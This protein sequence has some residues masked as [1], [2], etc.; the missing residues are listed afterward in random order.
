ME[1]LTHAPCTAPG[2]LQLSS[3]RLVTSPFFA[4]SGCHNELMPGVVSDR[5]I[6]YHSPT[7]DRPAKNVLVLKQQ[8]QLR[9]ESLLMWKKPNSQVY[10]REWYIYCYCNEQNVRWLD[11]IQKIAHPFRT[12][13]TMYFKVWSFTGEAEFY[14]IFIPTLIWLGAPVEGM[15]VATM[16]C[17]SQYITGTLKDMVCCPRPPCPPLELRGK[18]VTH[19]MEYGF[20]STH[21]SHSGI[22]AYF[23]YC[24]LSKCFPNYAF[25]CGLGAAFFL[26]NV[27]FSR[28]YLGMHWIGD[29]VGGWMV[30]FT[31]IIIQASFLDRWLSSVLDWPAAPCWAYM[32]GYVLLHAL[33]VSHAT[34]HDP[35]PCYI[36]SLRFAGVMLG[37]FYGFWAFGTQFK[38]MTARPRPESLYNTAFS[39]P[40][41]F[42]W[43]TCVVVV[44]ATKEIS[45]IVGEK[46]LKV[47]FKFLSGAYA[48]QM[49]WLLRKPYLIMAHLVGLTTWG[50]ERGLRTYVPITANASFDLS[51]AL[52]GSGSEPTG[53]AAEEDPSGEM[54]VAITFQPNAGKPSEAFSAEVPITGPDG[55]LNA[56]QAWSLR[57]HEH[58]WLWEVHKR[59]VSYAVTGFAVS[60]LCPLLLRVGFG[61]GATL[62]A[63]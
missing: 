62:P 55:Y 44:I 46:I 8:K 59:T 63:S 20:P 56:Y 40:F 15:Q 29:L 23:L 61:V 30:A 22:L 14:V 45:A 36:D 21:S 60:Y 57:T 50:R 42:Q 11:K 26:V 9:K 28:L 37:S 2:R 48:V 32:L 24:E 18:R 3:L 25:I 54:G 58:W 31:V 16:L 19:D 49:P 35:C 51:R 6:P 47:V 38:T 34:P 17:I 41:F 53:N 12:A 52:V 39:T 43:L 1:V 10:F 13:I 7:S 4:Q 5:S 27:C 33:A